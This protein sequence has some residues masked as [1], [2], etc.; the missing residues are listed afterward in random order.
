FTLAAPP[1]TDI[2]A[3]PLGSTLHVYSAPVSHTQLLKSS[4]SLARVSFSFT[5]TLQ[6]DQGGLLF[7]V[8]RKVNP[9]PTAENSQEAASHPAWIKAGIEVND[10]EPWVS[11]CGKANHGWVDWSL[12][13][14]PTKTGLGKKVSATIEFTWYKNALMIYSIRGEERTLVRKVPWAFLDD[15]ELSD[16]AWVGVYAARPDPD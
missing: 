3:T 16:H 10:G 4:F 12:V 6:F 2:Y 7:T 13:P 15:A 9:E 1:N 11:V 5:P 8:A 14:L